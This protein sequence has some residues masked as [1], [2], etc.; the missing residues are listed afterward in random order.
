MKN[1]CRKRL[2]IVLAVGMILFAGLAG[3]NEEKETKLEAE[4]MQVVED[5]VTEES[6]E[7][8]SVEESNS[9]IEEEVFEVSEIIDGVQKVKCKTYDELLEF[10]SAIDSTVMVGFSFN[11]PAVLRGQAILYDGA[12]YTMCNGEIFTIKSPKTI[13]Q[14]TST[15]GSILV[16]DYDSSEGVHEWDIAIFEIGPDIEVPLTITYEDGTEENLCYYITKDWFYQWEDVDNQELEETLKTDG[17]GEI[18][19]YRDSDE[20]LEIYCEKQG[21]DIAIAVMDN[22]TDQQI[23]LYDG[24]RC[25]IRNNVRLYLQSDGIYDIYTAKGISAARYY[26]GEDLYCIDIE[27]WNWE[28]EVVLDIAYEDGTRN[29][30][31]V[32]L[33]YEE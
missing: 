20:F 28:T 4:D 15:R 29:K 11:G 14:I 24:D 26:I 22:M 2:T 9:T 17:E 19:F 8:L 30:V 33:I 1:R 32:Y 5:S 21:E 18:T 6:S 7:E 3:C 23:I 12:H 10:T 25:T 27:E 31:T 16:S 13:S